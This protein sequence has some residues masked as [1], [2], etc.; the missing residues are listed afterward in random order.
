MKTTYCKSVGDLLYIQ[1]YLHNIH[2]AI[3]FNVKLIEMLT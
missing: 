1:H 3:C 2:T